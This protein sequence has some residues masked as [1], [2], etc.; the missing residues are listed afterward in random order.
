MDA[1]AIR[2]SPDLYARL[3]AT[4]HLGEADIQAFGREVEAINSRIMATLGQRDARYIRR[5]VFVQR[6][7]EVLG[8]L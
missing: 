1:P 6:L 4:C 8:N 7:L 2:P 3:S 5:L